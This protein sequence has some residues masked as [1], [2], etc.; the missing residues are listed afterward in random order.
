MN[1]AFPCSA[2]SARPLF[3]RR[4]ALISLLFLTNFR[5]GEWIRT[6]L[7]EEKAIAELAEPKSAEEIALERRARD[8]ER[9]A[10]KLQEE[11]ARSGLGADMQPVPEPTVRDLSVPQ[12]KGPA[13]PQNHLP[14]TPPKE[15]APAEP[16]AARR[17]A[18]AMPAAATTEE[19]LGRKSEAAGKAGGS[20]NRNARA[21]NRRKTRR[22]E[23]RTGH[24]HRRRFRAAAPPKPRAR[25]ESPSRSPSPRRR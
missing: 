7:K 4:C 15:T 11:V 2:R 6:F 22:A 3:I 19:I 10:K 17:T 5:L 23:T 16:A 13:R 20:Q 9:Q 14:G 1:T 8:L 12:A 21:E 18:P 25:R 24:P